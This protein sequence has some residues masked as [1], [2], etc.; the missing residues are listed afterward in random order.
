MLTNITHVT[1]FVK[2]H[3]EALDFYTIQLGFQIHTDAMFDGNMR[4]LTITPSTQSDVELTL[5]LAESAEEKA[6][7]GKQG[8]AKSFLD[9]ACDNCENTYE[10]LKKNGVKILSQPEQQP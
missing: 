3:N 4:C 8:G 10:F 6:L 1:L 2:D 5:M 7:I 9:F